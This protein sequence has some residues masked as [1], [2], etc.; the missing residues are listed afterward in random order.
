MVIMTVP[1]S[2]VAFCIAQAWQCCKEHGIADSSLAGPTQ[3]H[4][5]PL[6]SLSVNL[7]LSTTGICSAIPQRRTQL[8]I[9]QW[10]SLFSRQSEYQVDTELSS[11]HSSILFSGFGESRPFVVLQNVWQIQ[12]SYTSRD[13]PGTGGMYFQCCAHIHASEFSHGCPALQICESK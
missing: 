6:K 7:T 3:R 8:C 11:F 12:Q 1:S 10:V 9:C 13:T 2:S 4:I 5:S